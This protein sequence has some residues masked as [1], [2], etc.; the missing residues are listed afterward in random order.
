MWPVWRVLWA[1]PG[2][3]AGFLVSPF[4]R[5]RRVARGVIVCEGANWPRRI[6]F[7]HRAMTLGHVVLCVDDLD[8]G[9]LEHELVHV[10]QWERW[11]L[12][13]PFAYLVATI[14]AVLRGG[15]FYRD[16]IFEV[17]ARSAPARRA[18]FRASRSAKRLAARRAVPSISLGEAQRSFAEA[19]RRSESSAEA[20][21]NASG[22]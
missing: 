2:S 19:Q 15:H 13:F 20:Q 14:A 16:N 8:D 12:A 17:Q 4:F 22:H 11:G 9:V 6:G 1:S 10:R 5:A 7:R 21:R 3:V 18:G